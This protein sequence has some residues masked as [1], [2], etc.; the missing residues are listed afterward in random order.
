MEI[1]VREVFCEILSGLVV[2]L[3]VTAAV[4]LAGVMSIDVAWVAFTTNVS[5]GDVATVILICY[6]LGLIMDAV[7]VALGELF[8]D[9][10]L[11]S[12]EPSKAE[13]ARFWETVPEH[14]ITYRDVQW[15]YYSTYR[16]LFLLTIPTTILWSIVFCEINW[17]FSMVI[18]LV[19]V[20][21]EFAFWRTMTALLN[22]YFEL[23][24]IKYEKG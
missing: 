7:G 23:T 13:R 5:F 16:N 15:A 2:L 4:D 6:L 12:D 3:L 19:G 24:R 22:I 18:L 14:V 8:L 9:R 20:L 11:V 1:N 21:L 10:L 17:I